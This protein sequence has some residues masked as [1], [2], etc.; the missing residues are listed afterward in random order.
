MSRNLTN[1]VVAVF[2]AAAMVAVGLPGAAQAI[3]I[4][5]YNQT[6][7]TGDADCGIVSSNVPH[8]TAAVDVYESDEEG[9]PAYV[10]NGLTFTP[11]FAAWTYGDGHRYGNGTGW[12]WDVTTG[13]G[14]SV[15]IWPKTTSVAGTIGQVIQEFVYKRSTATVTF[16]GLTPGSP[17]QATF[18][19]QEAWGA[20]GY[21]MLVALTNSSN[22]DSY[23]YDVQ[24]YATSDANYIPA[25]KV[26]VT[27]VAPAGGSITFTFTGQDDSGRWQLGAF[28]NYQIPEP[29]TLALLAAGLAGLLCYAWRKRR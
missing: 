17:Y 8:Y 4:F 9:P 27:Y 15:A 1:S 20:C 3:P 16:S 11:S 22:A 29:G 10:V 2:V 26:D 28:T 25:D 12:A 23:S 13:N 6:Q 7:V 18:F 5:T 24:R 19:N 14:Y 21:N